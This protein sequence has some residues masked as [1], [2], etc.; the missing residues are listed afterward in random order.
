MPCHRGLPTD[1]DKILKDSR[2]RN[3]DLGYDDATSTKDNVVANLHQVIETRSS[4]YYSV[5][6]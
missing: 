2:T 5:P 3:A 6:H 4:A 1:L